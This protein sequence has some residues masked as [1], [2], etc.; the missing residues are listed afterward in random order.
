MSKHAA[1]IGSDGKPHVVG[2]VLTSET[3]IAFT[4]DLFHLNCCTFS[5]FSSVFSGVCLA[6]VR[7]FQG[8]AGHDIAR[9]K[10]RSERTRPGARAARNRLAGRMGSTESPGGGARD[11]VTMEGQQKGARGGKR[12]L[13]KVASRWGT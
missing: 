4:F 11:R 10:E 5:L 6:Y 9:E 12:L 13:Q 1:R 8:A 3:C 7:C 2:I